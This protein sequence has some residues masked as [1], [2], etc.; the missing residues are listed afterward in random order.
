MSTIRDMLERIFPFAYKTEY[1]CLWLALDACG[2][3]TALYKLKHGVVGATIPTIG[4]NVE[5]I[6]H[7]NSSFTIW[8][9]GGCDK[10]RPLWRHYFQET[11]GID[12]P[13]LKSSN[14]LVYICFV[15]F[16]S[17]ITRFPSVF[18]VTFLTLNHTFSYCSPCYF[19]LVVIYWTCFSSFPFLHSAMA[20]G[21]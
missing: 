7:K 9:V 4:F 20:L 16:C 6:E 11:K 19:A 14:Y 21:R 12:T 17:F 2:R 8:D 10:I 5:T 18:L 13:I 15:L 1:R 3:T